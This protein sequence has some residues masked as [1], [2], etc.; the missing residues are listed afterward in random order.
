MNEYILARLQTIQRELEELRTLL[1]HE[2]HG[3][4]SRVKLRGL[5][6]GVEI[7]EDEVR[8]AERAVFKDAYDDDE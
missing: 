2:I 5:W 7:T 1:A 3:P 8:E 6:K 4:P